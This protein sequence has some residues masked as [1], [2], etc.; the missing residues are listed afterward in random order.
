M[1]WPN[2]PDFDSLWDYDHPD[3]TEVKFREVLPQFAKN[4]S[5]YLELLTQIARTHSLRRKFDEAHQILDE[6]QKEL[7]ENSRVTVRYLFERGRAFN[8]AHQPE[9][10]KPLFEEAFERAKELKE[11][12][13]AVD[14]LHM[15]AIVADP[16][17]ALDL[18]LRAIQMAE[19]S[20]DEKARGW[21]GSLYN[22]LGWT[23]HEA[24]EYEAALEIFQKAE[25]FRR[26]R[27]DANVT[28]IAI[29]AVARCLRS[30]NRVEE[31]LS[32]Q[33]NLEKEFES[34]KETDGY[35]FEEIGECFLLL[36]Q[37]EEARP[38]LAKAYQ[39]LSQDQFL[40][41]HEAQRLARLKQLAA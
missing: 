36:D 27:N 28:R 13:Y 6:V 19:S 8:S 25:A 5:A 34:V 20:A 11:D 30:L 4:G 33:L 12:F 1:P 10:A 16:V 40:V 37:K 39:I 23:Y 2:L 41:E 29:W 17:S 21:L 9:K 22:N 7:K 18:N 26:S 32:R 38:Y 35:V 14:A 15:L 31:A 3:Q 24:K